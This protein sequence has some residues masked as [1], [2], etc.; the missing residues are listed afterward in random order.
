MQT[1]TVDLD[2]FNDAAFR[3]FDRRIITI[4][5]DPNTPVCDCGAWASL[6]IHGEKVC[7]DCAEEMGVKRIR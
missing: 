3:Y 6:N 2:R 4:N 5:C 1:P 7:Y